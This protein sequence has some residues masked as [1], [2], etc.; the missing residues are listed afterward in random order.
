MWKIQIPKT[1]SKV[2]EAT[3]FKWHK[4]EG[5]KVI[6][7]ELVAEIETFKA[8]VEINSPN[9]GIIYKIFVKCII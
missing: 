9:T 7:G 5:D 2:E 6:K 3:L 4:K 1:E 8:A